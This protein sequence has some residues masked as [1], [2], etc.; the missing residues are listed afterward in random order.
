MVNLPLFHVGGTGGVMVPMLAGAARS[1]IV[2]FVRHGSFWPTVHR[3]KSTT[4][5]LLGVMAS[6][7]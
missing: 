4:G 7:S 2:E 3:T 5:D 1:P 6:F